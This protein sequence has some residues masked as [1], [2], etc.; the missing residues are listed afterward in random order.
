MS[1][2]P[3]CVWKRNTLSDISV[4]REEPGVPS[5]SD[6]GGDPGGT[7]TYI[8]LWEQGVR[9]TAALTRLGVRAGDRVA[10]LLPMGLE[11]VV[12]TL[13]CAR[14]DAIRVTLSLDGDPVNDW[15]RRLLDSRASVVITADGCEIDQQPVSLKSQMD[16]TLAGCPAVR[17]VLVVRHAHRPV[18][19]TPGRDRWWR[20][21]LAA[22]A[23]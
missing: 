1:A 3:Q 22:E 18:P 10:V 11:S 23:L 21:A 4:V 5:V 20:E 12:S 2:D 9:A 8:Q 7:F 19:W 15:R 17:D 6:A 13:A 16:R 14:L